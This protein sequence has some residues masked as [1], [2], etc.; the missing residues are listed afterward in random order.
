[1]TARFF[2]REISFAALADVTGLVPPPGVGDPPGQYNIAPS[3]AAPIM[4]L[5]APSLYEGDYAPRDELMVTP[6]FWG[7]VPAW[8]KKPLSEKKYAS[9]NAP[10]DR[11]TISKTFS[12]SLRHG[13][14]LV[15]ASGFYTWSGPKGAST[16][17]AV[18]VSD[19]DWFCFAG[20]W[21]RAMIEGSEF[22][23]FAIITC[24][25]NDAMAGL[26]AHMPVILHE[27]DHARWLDPASRAPLGI[28]RPY[29]SVATRI[30]PANPGVGNVRNQ[31][32]EMTGE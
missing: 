8:W 1:M 24:A 17:F 29:P 20:L 4:R 11:L 30:W 14:C 23:T 31:G 12:G 13:R 18:S 27:D 32:P 9:F 10:V 25:A 16:P 6:A 2:R 5:S 3:D 21:S 22:D 19:R 26:S 7:L 28:L 15:P